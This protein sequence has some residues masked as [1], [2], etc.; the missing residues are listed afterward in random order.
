M[1]ITRFQLRHFGTYADESLELGGGLTVLYGPNETGKSTLLDAIRTLLFGSIPKRLLDGY[2]DAKDFR[3]TADVVLPGGGL[4]TF[5]RQ[6][7]KPQVEGRHEPSGEPFEAEDLAAAVRVSGVQYRALFGFSQEELADGEEALAKD[8]LRDVLFGGGVGDLGRFRAAEAALEKRFDELFTDR[9]TKRPINLA[10]KSVQQAAASLEKAQT[11]PAEYDELRRELAE[12]EREIDRQSRELRTVRSRI[13]LLKRLDRALALSEERRELRI[14][15]E[16]IGLDRPLSRSSAQTVLSQFTKRDDLVAQQQLY[17]VESREQEEVAENYAANDALL[18]S[19]QTIRDLGD[20][21]VA[22]RAAAARVEELRRG[23]AEAESAIED[24]VPQIALDEAKALAATVRRLQAV[25]AEAALADASVGERLRQ[26]SRLLAELESSEQATTDQVDLSKLDLLHGQVR[27]NEDEYRSL[28]SQLG[29]QEESIAAESRRLGDAVG[30]ADWP[31]DVAWPVQATVDQI[32]N[33]LAAAREQH[34]ETAAECDRIAREVGVLERAIERFADDEAPPSDAVLRQRRSDRDHRVDSLRDRAAEAKPAAVEDLDALGE[35]IAAADGVADARL[36]KA[37]QLG[38]LAEMHRSLDGL[39]DALAVAEADRDRAKKDLEAADAAWSSVW[40][41]LSLTPL[42]PV[43]M[44][45]WRAEASRLQERRESHRRT[46]R[47][48]GQL[49]E[50]RESLVALVS[51][52]RNEAG[53]TAIGDADDA[54]AWASQA[55]TLWNEREQLARR[56]REE[57]PRLREEAGELESERAELATRR[58]DVDRELQPIRDR[59]SLPVETTFDEL[60][61]RCEAAA[62]AAR[63]RLAIERDCTELKTLQTRIAAFGEAAGKLAAAHSELVY[64]R[65]PDT[66]VKSLAD[67]LSQEWSKREARNAALAAATRAA[68]KAAEIDG[69]LTEVLTRL[70][71]ERLA[72]GFERLDEV[73]EAAADAITWHDLDAEITTRTTTIRYIAD[74]EPIERFERELDE[75][76][77]GARADELETLQADESRLMV[78]LESSRKALAVLEE[79]HRSLARTGDVAARQ[80]ELESERAALRDLIDQYAPLAILAEAFGRARERFE[81]ERQPKLLDDVS[82]LLAKLTD[83]EHFA[84]RRSMRDGSLWIEGGEA[85]APVRRKPN[86]LSA[87]TRQLLYLAIRLAYIREQI[88]RHGPLPVLLDDVL[89][90]IDDERSTRVLSVLRELAESTQVILLTCHRR[91]VAFA[92]EMGL[93]SAVVSLPELRGGTPTSEIRGS[94]APNEAE[95]SAEKEPSA[96]KPKRRARRQPADAGLFGE[97]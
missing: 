91:V 77:A 46:L 41:P 29:P 45:D 94:A 64:E 53:D 61:R 3:L 13:G 14:Q 27:P 76:D 56:R 33:E 63:A 52:L 60:G 88:D 35:A 24:D 96:A 50:R 49:R 73:R 39:C 62:E 86:Q 72:G 81:R 67:L 22:M 9:S 8:D 69:R 83:G 1:R 97:D 92:C 70:D 93:E 43:A 38:K 10:M 15:Q 85:D 25:E 19:E 75:A 58:A 89:V 84:V 16:A 11:K 6:R 55:I 87:G 18:A 44:R 40:S 21:R 7:L 4:A 66:V 59:L 30:W 51:S 31:D 34:R 95:P 71:D 5:A 78:A 57:G 12:C 20:E 37:T 17:E 80:A 82:H 32:G 42:S 23:I 74:D 48:Y 68:D 28:E 54:I 90:H 47:R 79:K 65:T 26:T 2:A 36:E